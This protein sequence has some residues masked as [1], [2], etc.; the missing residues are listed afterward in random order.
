MRIALLTH[1][2]RGD[3]EPF[4]ALAVRLMQ[5]GHSVKLASRPDFAA[6][7]AEHGVE[8]CP[9]GNPY[10]PFISRAAETSA[11]EPGHPLKRLRFGFEQRKYVTENL[12]EDAWQAAQG[13]EAIIY[14][15]PWLTAYT[16]AE[17]LGIPC[18]P[19]ML[20]PFA[21]TQAFPNFWAGRGVDR[22]PLVN[23]LIWELPWWVV[24]QGLRLDDRKLRRTL[25][26]RSLPRSSLPLQQ[27][28][29]MPVFG[30][31]SPSVLPAPPDWP[32]RI[33]LTG[34]WF[35]DPPS[36]WRPP[37]ELVRFL[38]TGPPPVSI[39]FGSMASRDRE[40]TLQIVLRALELSGQRG[41]LLGG[42]EGLGESHELPDSIFVAPSLPHS[43]LFPQMAA[44]VHHGGAGTTG[45]GLRSGVPSIVT[46]LIAD[47]P[48]WGRVVHDL[49]AGPAPIPF[50]ELTA[51]RLAAAI[52]QAVTDPT[53]GQGA[54]EI[55]SKIQDEDGVGRTIQLFLD[56]VATFRQWS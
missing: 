37:A 16:V 22:G 29:E 7:A 17:K 32:N 24:W 30:A 50:A 40:A 54:G 18:A 10:Q 38:K 3:T 12:Q 43:W 4:L 9:L 52:T 19:A 23:R 39:G 42:W 35:L 46:P 1:P 44:V 41:V 51:D 20:L 28:P 2:G 14:K 53:I 21:S 48:S 47:Q 8:F 56:Y 26:V 13:A 11:M 25:G 33:H 36:S 34:Y 15:Y 5:M 49:G 45:A 27:R 31:W 6:L 55:G